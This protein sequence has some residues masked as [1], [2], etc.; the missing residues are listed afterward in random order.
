VRSAGTFD[1][2][3]RHGPRD[4]CRRAA[5]NERRV[6]VL[7][8][9]ALRVHIGCRRTAAPVL[10]RRY[11]LRSILEVLQIDPSSA[12]VMPMNDG[13]PSVD[14]DVVHLVPSPREPPEGAPR[15]RD[16]VRRNAEG[17]SA[18]AECS[19]PPVGKSQRECHDGKEDGRAS[20]MVMGMPALEY[21]HGEHA[22]NEDVDP[23]DAVR[24]AVGGWAA[25]AQASN[26]THHRAKQE[27]ARTD[28]DQSERQL[29]AFRI[30]AEGRG[31]LQK[32]RNGNGGTLPAARP[33]RH[34]EIGEL[35][36]AAL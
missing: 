7:H 31:T 23:V 10:Q 19:D 3:G 33:E 22:G 6:D 9:R 32:E 1:G 27:H 28:L 15:D 12:A 8:F 25:R 34:D 14:G 5:G 13:L 20:D 26:G 24:M 11:H 36:H 30:P 18:A 4:G 35:G 21:L 2:N 17:P 16:P 29:D